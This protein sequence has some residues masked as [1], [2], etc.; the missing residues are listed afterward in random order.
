MT[1]DN[2]SLVMIMMNVFFFCFCFFFLDGNY[3]N[4]I[5]LLCPRP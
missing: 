5:T 4:P 2:L 3:T 1:K